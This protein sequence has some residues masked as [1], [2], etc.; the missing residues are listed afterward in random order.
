M[1]IEF[2]LPTGSGGQAA[3][4]TNAVLTR[5]LDAWSQRYQVPYTKKIF[6]WTLRVTFVDEKNYSLFA[7]TW[8][9]TADYMVDYIKNY[10]LVE[11]MSRPS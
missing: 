8:Q 6:K 7:M 3:Q 10:K 5:N 11:P 2:Q 4:Y 9:P 1:Y